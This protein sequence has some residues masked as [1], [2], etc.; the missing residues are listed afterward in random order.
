MPRN[1]RGNRRR[2]PNEIVARTKGRRT[3]D[4]PFPL[5]YNLRMARKARV[6]SESGMYHIVLKGN[7][8]LLFAEDDDYRH[9]L[10]LLSKI[11]ER[12]LLECYAYCLFS[13]TAHLAVKEGLRP[14]GESIKSLVSA[15]AVRCN[16]KYARAGKL[17]YDR[18][19]SEPIETD[20]E[21][22]DAV[23]FIHA[24]P[25]AHGEDA[26][27]IYS[28]YGN[29]VNKK[30]LRSD[31]LMLLFDDSVVRFREE[32]EIAPEHAFA[33]GENKVTLSDA[34]VVALVRR[35]TGSMTAK[36]AERITLPILGELSYNL[37]REGASI[38]QLS[39]VLQVSKSA[40]ERAL[41]IHAEN[42]AN[43]EE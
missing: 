24:L 43:S 22:T 27:Y 9:F 31:S 42:S 38:R 16:E 17:F 25:K 26:T 3:L 1:D 20:E 2:L 19:I 23:R 36:E 4:L 21:L 41:K 12:D 40:V 28:S 30:G 10:L 39:R 8:K 15:Y 18:Y 32:M 5:L 14:I 34:Q 13:E 6:K 37:C 11:C 33:S 7:D 29:Y 35:M